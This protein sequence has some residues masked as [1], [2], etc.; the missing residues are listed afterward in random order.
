MSHSTGNLINIISAAPSALAVV[1]T[2]M[3]YLAASQKWV[4]DYGLQGKQIVGL[5]HYDIFP[6][7]GAEWKTIHADCLR[8]KAKKNAEDKFI[9]LDGTVQWLS[10]DV[11]PWRNDNGDIDGMIMYSEDITEQKNVEN[12][13]REE[14][15]LLRTLIN[16]IPINIFIKDLESRK[17]MVNR[18]ECEYMGAKSA[19]EILG[20]D[21]YE[22]YPMALA[23]ISIAEDQ[24][25]FA[26][27]KAIINR[28]KTITWKDGSM[29]SLL[30]SK[31]PLLSDDG[32]IAGLL[33]I[34]YDISKIKDAE[35]ALFESEQK[36]RK[37]FENI[38]D[39]FYQTDQDGTITEISPSIEH[40]SGYSRKEV[41][42]NPVNNFYYDI[43]D[44][45]LLVK[46]LKEKHKV[47]D[48]EV[49]LKT[50]A[51]EKRYSSVNAQLIIRN[52]EIVGTE[53]SM[54]DVTDRK[55]QEDI[56]KSLNNDLNLL[57]DQKNKL[58][59][60]IAHDLRNPISGCAGLLE[61]VFMN[62]D[63]TSKEELIEY[64]KMMQKSVLNAH[65]LLEDLMEWAKIQFNSVDFNPALITDLQSQ[66]RHCLKKIEPLADTKQ[67][68]ISRNLEEGIQ[69]MADKY[70][71]DSIIRNLVTNAVKF[72]NSRG[73]IEVSA[74]KEGSGITF[75]VSDNG[76]GI[77]PQDIGKLFGKD[78]GFTSYGTLGEKGTGMGLGLCRN[79]VEKHGG[80]IHVESTL[81]KG[82]TFYFNIPNQQ[83]LSQNTALES[84]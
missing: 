20:K 15:E 49:R 24:E 11:R 10:W 26:S 1:D 62:I 35:S 82:S 59:S 27:G 30:T 40:H 3:C 73:E 7:I 65:E 23:R 61:V 36:F 47:I 21:D 39:V 46:S 32:K 70:M 44:R 72:T 80:R 56:L 48:F 9:R 12:A 22:L 66:V 18:A 34:N 60:V 58:L 2:K 63:S 69:I 76:V 5:S 74:K 71:L 4:E 29:R 51:G 8:G 55:L 17:T 33:G 16:N 68:R 41:I 57:N 28:E 83:G 14:R 81:G 50:K 45:K 79:F 75:S 37:I 31:I 64:M 52:G 77:A 67:I 19:D 13:L 84:L 42:G 25:V 43:G 78:A 54:R 38:Q 6:E 53:G